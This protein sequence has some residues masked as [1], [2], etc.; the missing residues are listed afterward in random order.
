MKNMFHLLSLLIAAT[1]VLLV[2]CDNGSDGGGSGYTGALVTADNLSRGGTALHYHVAECDGSDGNTIQVGSSGANQS[3]TFPDYNWIFSVTMNCIDPDST[4]YRSD[5]PDADRA[6]MEEDYPHY[7]YEQISEDGCFELGAA[8]PYGTDVYPEAKLKFP[9]PLKMGTEW[10]EFEREVYWRTGNDSSYYQDSIVY[11]ADAWGT[12]ITPYDTCT[13]IRV[14]GHKWHLNY[15]SS[16]E[17]YYSEDVRYL[18][19]NEHG[20]PV[21]EAYSNDDDTDPDFH[22]GIFAMHIP[23]AVVANRSLP[24]YKPDLSLDEHGSHGWFG[25]R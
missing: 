16:G 10:T 3:W 4:L 8:G 23:E 24:P 2:G 7:Y 17:V 22:A 9:L 6:W 20:D 1:A 11:A 5:F 13:C 12:L 19:Y 14:F 15:I 18:W 25:S 21:I